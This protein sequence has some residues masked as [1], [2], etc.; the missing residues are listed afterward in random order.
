MTTERN[1]IQNIGSWIEDGDYRIVN[2]HSIFL[3]YPQN[4]DALNNLL[5]NT[6]DEAQ[7]MGNALVVEHG[8][9]RELVEILN[10]EGWRVV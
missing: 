5:D 2:H 1:K 3:V 9:I 6:D 10:N 8:Y 4:D 7:F